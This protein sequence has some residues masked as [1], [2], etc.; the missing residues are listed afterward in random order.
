MLLVF[1]LLAFIGNACSFIHSV[2]EEK[3]RILV[4]L[5]AGT[6]KKAE[7]RLKREK[8]GIRMS[9][10]IVKHYMVSQI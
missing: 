10:W 8:V 1:I 2:G 5:L 4:S 3:Y 9:E 6:F 7:R